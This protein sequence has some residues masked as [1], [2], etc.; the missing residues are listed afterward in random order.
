[1]LLG[2][3]TQKRPP[4]A[5]MGLSRRPYESVLVAW[6]VYVLESAARVD[7]ASARAEMAKVDFMFAIELGV[8]LDWVWNVMLV[9]YEEL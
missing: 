3:L 5:W 1:M 6:R 9:V 2:L 4:F 7:A 8:G